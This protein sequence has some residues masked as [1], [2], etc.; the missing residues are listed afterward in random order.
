MGFTQAA[1]NRAIIQD[2]KRRYLLGEI[3]RE[4]AKA[5]AEPIIRKINEQ[6]ARIAKKWKKQHAPQTFIGLMR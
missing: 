5:E 3:T 4:V 6:S 2:I 1:N